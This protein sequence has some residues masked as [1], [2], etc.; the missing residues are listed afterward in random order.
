MCGD[1]GAVDAVVDV[2][3]AFD[4]ID[5]VA[6]HKAGD[7]LESS[8]LDAKIAQLEAHSSKFAVVSESSV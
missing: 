3:D 2:G 5:A 4:L 8:G 6:P 7:P 1:V